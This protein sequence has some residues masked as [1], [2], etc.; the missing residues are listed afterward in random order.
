MSTTKTHSWLC[1]LQG[2][3]QTHTFETRDN[4]ETGVNFGFPPQRVWYLAVCVLGQ[5]TIP[6]WAFIDVFGGAYSLQTYMDIT[7]SMWE[8]RLWT[9][10]CSR[11]AQ[12]A[13]QQEQVAR[14]VQI[15]EEKNEPSF[16]AAQAMLA[17]QVREAKALDSEQYRLP[18]L[19]SS[20]CRQPLRETGGKPSC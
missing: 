5:D 8:Q 10:V 20:E 12:H 6:F 18:T 19:H 3:D 1:R 17:S 9:P 16:S 13:C 4:E 11:T 2:G 15:N 7:A 14:W